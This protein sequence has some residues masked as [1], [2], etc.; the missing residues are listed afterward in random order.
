MWFLLLACGSA[1]PAPSTSQVG[2]AGPPP[3]GARPPGPPGGPGG[4]PGSL[5]IPVDDPLWGQL[6]GLLNEPHGYGEAT[7]DDVRMRV[8]GHVA[9]LGR[10]RARR[11]VAA[12]DWA[13]CAA[14]YTD[15]AVRM[16]ALQLS[17]SSGPPIRTALAAAARR[18][19]GFCDAL[20]GGAVPPVGGGT[21]APLRARWVQLVVRAG[22]GEDVRADAD[23]L[24]ADARAIEAPA[25]DLAAFED[26]EARHRLRVRLVE[27]W[28]DAV[29]PFT[30]TEPFD[31]WTAAEVPRQSAGIAAASAALAGGASPDVR[32]ADALVAS[33]LPPY[34]ADELGSLVTGDSLVDTLGFAGPKAIGTLAKLG[35]ADAAH[36]PWLESTAAALQAALPAAVPALVAERAAE[37][38]AQPGG[39]RYY[40]IKQLRNTAVRHLASGGH[41]TEALAVLAANQPLHAQDWACPDRAAI[42]LAMQGR[43]ELLAGLPTAE[44]T[45]DRGLAEVDSFLAHVARVEKERP[46]APRFTP[47]HDSR[48]T[49]P[50]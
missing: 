6:S 41:F 50:P 3:A 16:D 8:V 15:S 1:P 26:F 46:A 5:V 40:A 35:S 39:I 2:P 4:P 27:A 30:P 9:V 38:D 24:A 12:G 32:A 36:R 22:R 23:Q 7:W 49:G 28:A 45:L 20:G 43:L 47:A 37:L 25:L 19:A 42:L 48:G 11:A 17:G 21:V 34:S 10:D 14:A 18:D 31:Y 29:S 33:P 44:A 13:G